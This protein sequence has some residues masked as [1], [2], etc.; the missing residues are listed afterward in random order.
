MVLG[1]L[2]IATVT[3]V[4]ILIH[5]YN[6]SVHRAHLLDDRARADSSTGLVSV[7]GPLNYL[8]LGSDQRPDNPGGGKRSDT[9]IVVHIPVTLDKAYLISIP[10]DL[11]VEIPASPANHFSGGSDKI[12]SAFDYGGGG[13]GGVQLLSETLTEL[14]GVRFDGAAIINFTGFQQVVYL[15]GGVT[16]C[17]DQQTTSIHTGATYH[18]GCQHLRPW[19]ALDYVRQREDL[20]GGDYDRQRHQ[21]Q[22][23]KAL[24]TE[25]GSRADQQPGQARPAHPRG[26]QRPHRR[27]QRGTAGLTDVLA[28]Q[29]RRERP[30]R[31]PAA[32][33]S[34]AAQRHQL[35]LPQAAG[36]H[37]VPGHRARLRRAVAGREPGVAQPDLT[38]RP[39]AAL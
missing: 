30:V 2:G 15:L 11:F 29:Y 34:R 14:T 26:G 25:A 19:Q 8:L 21:Q 13:V 39:A 33:L 18:P 3:T 1:L 36:G 7:K 24:L 20:P 9:I 5:R 16:M 12:N 37:P 6:T 31:R 10:R 32:V 38:A 17:I 23:L 28:A 22:F 4:A 27:H 35:R